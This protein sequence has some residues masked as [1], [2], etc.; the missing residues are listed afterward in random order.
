VT[1]VK[2]NV[3]PGYV[4]ANLIGAAQV[5]FFQQFIHGLN[6]SHSYFMGAPTA[7]NLNVALGAVVGLLVYTAMAILLTVDRAPLQQSLCGVNVILVAS[8]FQLWSITLGQSPD[9][10]GISHRRGS[11]FDGRHTSSRQRRQTLG[12][13]RIDSAI[14]VHTWTLLLGAYSYTNVRVAAMGPAE[15]PMFDA[16]ATA[17][18][19][20]LYGFSAVLT[21]MAVGSGVEQPSF[22][23]T[24]HRAGAT[25]KALPPIGIPA[26]T[27][28]Y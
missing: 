20:G 4:D 7:G 28:L 12:C 17:T 13:N 24:L 21:A 5:F 25:D 14:L 16:K 23:A 22:L 19:R 1:F 3:I 6:G 26:L 10:A 8:P 18:A 2:T 9:D 27:C 15:L 11:R